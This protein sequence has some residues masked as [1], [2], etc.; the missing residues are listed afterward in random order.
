MVKVT[1]VHMRD[2]EGN[3]YRQK[4][5]KTKEP[6]KI[7]DNEET[8]KRR[9]RILDKYS[10][11]HARNAL[12]PYK[13]EVMEDGEVNHVNLNDNTMKIFSIF[14]QR[15]VEQLTEHAMVVQK[16]MDYENG[17][18][19][20]T[21]S[22]DAVANVIVEYPPHIDSDMLDIINEIRSEEIVLENVKKEN[23]SKKRSNKKKD[24][25][26]HDGEEE[27]DEK[28]DEEQTD[29]TEKSPK[30]KKKKNA[31]SADDEDSEVTPKTKSKKS[32]NKKNDK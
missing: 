9:K 15:S 18:K 1:A 29:K 12:A 2:N 3:V 32:Q 30:S 22:M 5:K 11:C 23:A 16:E 7:E 28:D 10:Q 31:K 27:E 6:K 20:K 4:T 25:G 17:I 26:D 21:I 13:F 19:S 24:D 14:M 8:K